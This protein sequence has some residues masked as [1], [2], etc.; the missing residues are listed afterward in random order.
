MSHRKS[1]IDR[2]RQAVSRTAVRTAF[3][4]LERLG[5]ELGAAWAER[6]SFTVPSIR[7]IPRRHR[8]CPGQRLVI[9]LGWQRII[10]ESW[11]DGPAVHLVHGWGGRRSDLGALVAPLTAAG[12]RVVAFDAPGHGQ[13]AGAQSGRPQSSLAEVRDMIGA[14]C[15]ADGPAYGIVAHGEGSL[16]VGL[17]MRD[18]LTV[19]R[20]AFIA[21]ISALEPYTF[22]FAAR[23]GIGDRVYSLLMDRAQRRL[24]V[25]MSALDLTKVPART[26]IQVGQMPAR[27]TPPLLLVHDRD[28]RRTP[29]TDSVAVADAWPA[30]RLITTTGLGHRRILRSPMIAS[31]V[32]SF[33]TDDD[34]GRARDDADPAIW[35]ANLT[36]A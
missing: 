29:W 6:M 15:A 30:A 35:S 36:A 5:P 2:A 10:G 19:D 7:P 3:R 4:T 32:V 20:L 16:A 13:S 22:Q 31:E 1:T 34:D 27:P 21:P 8:P 26:A 14:A 23:H 17:A 24:G 11:G 28:D 12:F 33:L 25:P 9:R 18:G